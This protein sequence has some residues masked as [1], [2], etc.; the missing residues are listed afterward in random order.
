MNGNAMTSPDLSALLN[1]PPYPA[2]GYALL[3]DR[4]AKLLNSSHD[5]LLMQGEAILS[6][7]AVATSIARPSLHALNI[8][9]S[10]Y[11]A[12]FGT[13]LRRGGVDVT[14]L[15]AAAGK[16]ISFEAVKQAIET[17]ERPFDLLAL[18]H[19]ESA[20]GILNP[21]DEIAEL[22]AAHGIFTVVDAVAS[23]GGHGL[24]VNKS[25]LDIVVIGP[26]KALG[27]PAGI[28]AISISPK[29]WDYFQHQGAPR[30]SILSIM[31]QKELWLDQGRGALPGTPSSLEFFAYQ[32][33]LD[34][35]DQE[36]FD[37]VL[38]RHEATTKATRRAINAAGLKLWADDHNSSNL[39]TAAIVPETITRVDLMQRLATI[40]NHTIGEAV[41]PGTDHL[42]RINHT[43][44]NA[45][46]SVVAANVRALAQAMHGLKCHFDEE[47]ALAVLTEK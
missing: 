34:R 21:L 17:A 16:S 10:P 39:V 15:T 44:P 46:L 32:A 19:A 1:L 37:A 38:A 42:I 22:A 13:W 14:D 18:V 11:G 36:G 8:V 4:T 41:G 35:I 43:G 29:A 12:W 7:E 2:A 6:L 27:G 9:T 24:D 31:D 20:S 28:S 45:Q 3:A 5:I 25:K 26:Q 47:A 23:V 40:A 33:A 30:L